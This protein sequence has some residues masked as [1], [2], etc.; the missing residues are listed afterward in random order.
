MTREEY[1][2]AINVIRT[3]AMLSSAI[4]WRACM[5]AATRADAIGPILDPT[6]YHK[7]MDTH[8]LIKRGLRAALNFETEMRAIE[9]VFQENRKA[10]PH[11]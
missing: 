1:D 4:D 5:D 9:R 11:G 8:E 7:A 10:V 2:E 3:M 6:L